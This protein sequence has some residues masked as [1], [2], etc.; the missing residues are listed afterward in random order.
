MNVKLQRGELFGK[1]AVVCLVSQARDQICMP[2]VE[3]ERCATCAPLFAKKLVAKQS[4]ELTVRSRSFF[5]FKT[6]T[7]ATRRD[8]IRDNCGERRAPTRRE[9]RKNCNS[10]VTHDNNNNNNNGD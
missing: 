7:S 9:L 8:A 6:V 2:S 3:G 10:F 1:L 4:A 5:T